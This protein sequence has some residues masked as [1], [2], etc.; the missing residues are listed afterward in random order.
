MMT[1]RAVEGK[2]ATVVPTEELE[3]DLANRLIT[4]WPILKLRAYGKHGFIVKHSKGKR[5]NKAY[6]YEKH[7]VIV[8]HWKG[9]QHQ[10]AV[11]VQQKGPTAH[12]KRRS[13]KF[14]VIPWTPLLSPESVEL[15]DFV[16]AAVRSAVRTNDILVRGLDPTVVPMFDLITNTLKNAREKASERNIGTLVELLLE[17]HDPTAAVR[18][19][20]DTDNAHERIRFMENVPCLTSAQLAEQLGHGAKNKSQ[21][22]SR[23]KTERKAFSVPWRGREEYPAFQ[24]RDGRPLPVI[25]AVLEALP[26]EMTPWQIAFWFVSSNPWLDGKVPYTMLADTDAIVRAARQE[27]EAIAG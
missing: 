11:H 22:A 15:R 27:D 21:T 17:S 26:D 9:N 20:I 24:F 10:K 14:P 1:P 25:A 6:A 18:A 23:W 16:K 19:R 4:E 13:G 2:I 12:A 3:A 5:Y 7:G 8:K